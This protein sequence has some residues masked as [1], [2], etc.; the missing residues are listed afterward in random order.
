MRGIKNQSLV[1]PVLSYLE[2]SDN[3]FHAIK[4]LQEIGDE[5]AVEPI[6]KLL[7]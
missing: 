5:R 1:E 3:K 4:I 6:T 2:R 7:P